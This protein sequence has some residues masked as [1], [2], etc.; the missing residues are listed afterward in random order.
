[1]SELTTT[2]NLS[3]RMD[4]ER[5]IVLYSYMVNSSSNRVCE[6]MVRGALI[7][8]GRQ[9]LFSRGEGEEFNCTGYPVEI[10]TWEVIQFPP[11]T[12]VQQ[13]TAQLTDT[14]ASV[15]LP[16]EVDPSRTLVLAGGQWAS[17]QVHGEGRFYFEELQSEMRAQAF[18]SD[19]KH[20]KL[21]RETAYTPATF[22][23]FV[24]QLKP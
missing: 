12:F 23:V 17:G 7:S 20:V 9:V 3:T 11:G 2:V 6:R 22:T 24:I 8:D 19:P 13:V 10:L 5:S 1:M 18:L 14:S 15:S 16:K 4:P 21:V